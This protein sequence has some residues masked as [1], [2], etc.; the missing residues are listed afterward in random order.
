MRQDPE[1]FNGGSQANFGSRVHGD[2]ETSDLI[3]AFF[4]Q[5]KRL[6]REE[7]KLAK[8]EIR[9][10]AAQA[11]KGAGM[12]GGGAWL[13][14]VG[15][16]A[17]GAFLMGLL[18]IWLPFWASALIVSV[19]FLGVGALVANA[20]RTAIKK[21]SLKPEQTTQTLKEDK[22]WINETMHA[23]KLRRHAEA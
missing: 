15:G 18:A 14:H 7:V 5:A 21:V 1:R 11:G 17:F 16:L 12:L 3:S 23:V 13:L 9:E 6:V 8:S 22:A 20:G 2:A 10:E 4:D 19:L